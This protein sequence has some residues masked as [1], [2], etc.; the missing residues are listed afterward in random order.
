MLLAL[1]GGL[2]HAI[3]CHR[4]IECKGDRICVAGYCQDPSPDER[5]D[6]R[7]SAGTTAIPPPPPTTQAPV[8]MPADEGLQGLY[9]RTEIGVGY[10]SMSTT[11]RA[12]G[13]AATSTIAGG[14]FSLSAAFGEA[15][16]TRL[17]LYGYASFGMSLTT[18]SVSMDGQSGSLD[19]GSGLMFLLGPGA[20][21]Y[22]IKDVYVAAVVG[23]WK[24]WGSQR[25]VLGP[26]GSGSTGIGLAVDVALGK[27]WQL[28]GNTMAL[29]LAAHVT[30]ADASSTVPSNPGAQIEWQP[31][32]GSLDLIAHY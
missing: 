23:G 4:D 6:D 12:A 3:P 15:L 1:L 11:E 10:G 30:Y 32:L 26:S 5:A 20:A 14:L 16:G 24:G 2:A 22:F 27:E 28:P 21:Y 31:L 19:G 7:T 17:A 29:G 18:P 25:Q 9:V 13:T 8:L